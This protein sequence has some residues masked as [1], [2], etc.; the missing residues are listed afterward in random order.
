ME[1]H[2]QTTTFPQSFSARPFAFALSA[3]SPA[4]PSSP[5]R[6]SS[7][8]FGSNPVL[9]SHLSVCSIVSANSSVGSNPT[10]GAACKVQQMFNPVLPDELLPSRVGEELTVVQS[11]GDGWCLVGRQSNAFATTTKSLF[12]EEDVQND[13]ELGVVPAWCFL[14]PIPGLSA[15]R[16][17][18]SSSLGIAVQTSGPS[19][20]SRDD[21]RSWSNF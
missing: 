3:G 9:G 15:E 5:T 4:S 7:L 18:R 1:F 21:V 10:V 17:V 20:S 11:F 6:S 19:F 2:C 14:K 16:P 8:S 12:R 13:V